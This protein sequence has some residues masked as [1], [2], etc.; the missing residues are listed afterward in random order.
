MEQH[1]AAISVTLTP[2]FVGLLGV[3]W[4]IVVG[5]GAYWLK[6]M[7]DK[8][9]A[10][11]VHKEGCLRSFADKNSNASDHA[12]FFRRTNDHERRLTR[13]ECQRG[14]SGSERT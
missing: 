2:Y 5:F 10:L 7:S 11:T 9:D 1:S 12:E 4:F 3:L 13:L 14:I 6:R 8:L